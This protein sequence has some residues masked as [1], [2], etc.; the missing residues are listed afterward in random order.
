MRI[1]LNSLAAFLLLTSLAMFVCE[2]PPA[3]ADDPAKADPAKK[4]KSAA[5][6]SIFK[7]KNLEAAVRAEVYAKRNSSD[8]IVASDVANISRVVGKGK[9]IADLSGLE[10]CKALMLIDFE[11]NQIKDLTPIAELKRLQSVTLAGNK[12]RDIKPLQG[13]VA[14]QLLD[15]SKNQIDDLA[16][17]KEMSNLRTLYVANNQLKSIESLSSLTKVWSLDLSQNQISNLS[18]IRKFGWL[19]TLDITGNEVES[20]ESLTE[21]HE[22]DILMMSR[23]KVK[24]LSPLVKMC[25]KDAEGDRRFAPYL[26][27]YLGENPIDEKAKTQQVNKLQSFGVDV[28]DQ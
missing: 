10:H 19:T 6:V 16:P 12:I 15:L 18:P 3:K 7:D 27:V 8:P 14:M 4:E 1:S 26:D 5:P 25:R 20:L 2:S 11:N 23:N 22:L 24:D 21:L 28:Y 13:L 9:E 17:I